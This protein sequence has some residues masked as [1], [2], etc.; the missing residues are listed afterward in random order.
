MYEYAIFSFLQHFELKD[1]SFN[2]SPFLFLNQFIGFLKE[3]IESLICDELRYNGIEII[4]C[5][6]DN[7]YCSSFKEIISESANRCSSI[8]LFG[9]VVG[10]SYHQL[11]EMDKTQKP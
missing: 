7:I 5:I 1:K 9:W 6:V 10:H 8:D 11:P 4:L 3:R 2:Q